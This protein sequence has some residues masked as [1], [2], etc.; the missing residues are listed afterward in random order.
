MGRV[1]LP[2]P[3][4]QRDRHG[5][6]G[7]LIAGAPFP[8]PA[9]ADLAEAFRWSEHRTVSKTGLVS[10]HGNRYQVD[11]S[12]AGRKVELV[13]DPFDLS[14]LR[15]RSD[16]RDAGTAHRSRSAATPIPKPGPKSPPRSS[17]PP[18]AL[19]TWA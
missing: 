1:C 4:S 8:V 5:A 9:A 7:P 10:L 3:H 19:T 13:F 11:P 12:L 16:G 6:A 15:V 2:P 14:F 17:R 18:P